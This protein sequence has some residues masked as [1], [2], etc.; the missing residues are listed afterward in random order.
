[1]RGQEGVVDVS[2]TAS[3]EGRVPNVTITRGSGFPGLDRSVRDRLTGQ[4]MSAFP[5]DMPQAEAS[6]AVPALHAGAIAGGAIVE[7]AVARMAVP[8]C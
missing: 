6:L 4:R 3:R 5:P 1:M 2:F 8:G 7:G